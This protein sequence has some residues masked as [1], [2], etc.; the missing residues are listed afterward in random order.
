MPYRLRQALHKERCLHSANLSKSERRQLVLRP[1]FADHYRSELNAGGDGGVENCFPATPCQCSSGTFAGTYTTMTGTNQCGYTTIP[2]SQ[3]N[4]SDQICTIGMSASSLRPVKPTPTGEYIFT[5]TDLPTSGSDTTI[6]GCTSTYTTEA[7]P[8]IGTYCAGSKTPLTT[9]FP[10]IQAPTGTPVA[11]S[12]NFPLT[13]IEI[14]LNH[15]GLRPRP[16]PCEP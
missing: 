2:S 9:I 8:V 7:G 14:L 11:S 6:Y 15:V 4:P 12:C 13:P 5:E 1:H 3:W 10:P 16:R